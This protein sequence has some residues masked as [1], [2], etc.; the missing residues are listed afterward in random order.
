MKKKKDGRLERIPV[1]HSPNRRKGSA[2][3]NATFV[4]EKRGIYREQGG[5]KC[6]ERIDGNA[7]DSEERWQVCTVHGIA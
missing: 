2:S 1:A 3:S 4:V 5:E 7:L 6:D